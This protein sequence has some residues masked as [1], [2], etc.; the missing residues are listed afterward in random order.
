MGFGSFIVSWRKVI[1]DDEFFEKFE[2]GV[3]KEILI[4][5]SM[6][7]SKVIFIKLVGLFGIGK[8]GSRRKK[9]VN[10]VIKSFSFCFVLLIVVD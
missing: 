3:M 4:E 10:L 8:K 1:D 9:R 2:F 5:C 6:V 7:G